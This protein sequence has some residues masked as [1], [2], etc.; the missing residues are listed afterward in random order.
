MVKI[1]KNLVSDEIIKEVSYGEINKKKFIIIHETGNKKKGANAKNHGD[2]QK[3]GNSREA[4][5]HYSVDEKEAVKSFNH[6]IACW[7]AG[8]K[9]G[10]KQGIQIEICVNIDGDF[11]KAVDNTAELIV[12]VM[13]EENISLENVKQHYDFSGK[14]CPENLRN[15]E[16]GIYFSD[17]IEKVK[18][19]LKPKT[20]TKPKPPIKN[21]KPK[22]IVLVDQLNYYNS[23][24]WKD[25]AGIV[26]KG[27]VLTIEGK[28]LVEGVYQYK[29]ISGTYITS[30]PK[31]IKLI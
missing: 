22:L 1:T 26:K 7:A 8:S 31:Y 25:P 18:E 5:W 15:G 14:N 21:T 2:L 3:N 30:S 27:T 23:P 6:N 29:L 20:I 12:V 24:Q 19:L 13:K 11:K 16:K 9:T 17:L 28:V 4:S 10:N